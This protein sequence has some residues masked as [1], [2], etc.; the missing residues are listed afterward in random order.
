MLAYA[1]PTRDNHNA[2][3]YGLVRFRKSA[4]RRAVAGHDTPDASPPPIRRS[5]SPAGVSQTNS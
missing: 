5:S 4:G 3:G 1:N 2:A